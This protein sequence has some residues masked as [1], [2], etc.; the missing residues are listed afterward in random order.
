MGSPNVGLPGAVSSIASQDRTWETIETRNA[1]VDFA[2]LNSRLTGSF[3]Y[4]IKNNRNMLVNDQLP[5]TL[6]GSAPTQNIG[7]LEIE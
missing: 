4:Y 6:G 7:K 3:D 5:A 1:G 2:F